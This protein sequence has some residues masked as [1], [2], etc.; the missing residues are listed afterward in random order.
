M[1]ELQ[2]LTALD[3]A[4]LDAIAR[5]SKPTIPIKAIGRTLDPAPLRYVELVRITNNRSGDYWGNE[6]VY[7]GIYRMLLHWDINDEG[8]YEPTTYVDELATFFPKDTT[9]FVG[10]V[11]VKIYDVPDASGPVE[12]GSELLFPLSLRYRCFRS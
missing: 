1:N 5:S 9:F 6:R 12:N 10:D 11:A 4:A 8:V 7:Q 3:D 2:I